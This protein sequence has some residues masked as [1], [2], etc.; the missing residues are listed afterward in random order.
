MFG[1]KMVTQRWIRTFPKGGPGMDCEKK[2][3]IFNIAKKKVRKGTPEK[4]FF[5]FVLQ[6]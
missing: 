4:V 6:Y 2:G 1:P 5:V 3:V